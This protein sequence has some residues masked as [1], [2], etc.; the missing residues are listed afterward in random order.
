MTASN[1]SSAD[2]ALTNTEPYHSRAV[3]LA[4]YGQHIDPPSPELRKS[5]RNKLPKSV[6]PQRP[7]FINL[8]CSADR[9]QKL[10]RCKEC[11]LKEYTF[12]IYSES[13]II[14]P[15]HGLAVRNIGF[16]SEGTGF[17]S[18]CGRISRLVF[19]FGHIEPLAMCLQEHV[20][21]SVP[22]AVIDRD[23]K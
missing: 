3:P 10:F 6:C 1:S 11:P 22:D 4:T 7:S 18:D 21:P 9:K 2:S 20:K 5:S 12:F 23:R 14:E 8:Y 13:F 16:R 17:D 19:I 15:V